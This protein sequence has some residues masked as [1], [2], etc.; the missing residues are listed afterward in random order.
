MAPMFGSTQRWVPPKVSKPEQPTFEPAPSSPFGG[1]QRWQPP[2]PSQATTIGGAQRWQP[3]KPSPSESPKSTPT[4]ASQPEGRKE[5]HGASLPIMPN[6]Q[7]DAP[8]KPP[9]KPKKRKRDSDAQLDPEHDEAAATPKKHKTVLS[10]FEKVSR[11]VKKQ[12][13]Q[14]PQDELES[15]PEVVLRGLQPLPQPEPVPEP[16]FKP[17]FSVLPTWLAQPITVEASKRVP[18]DQLGVEPT[19]VKKL[20][21]HGYTEALAVQSVLLPMLQ[22]GYGQ[23]VGDICV[24]A[25]TGSGKTMAYLLPI[26]EALR[27]RTT[28]VLSAI[29]VVPTRQLVDQ[30][31]QVAEELCAGTKIKVGTAVGSVPFA[32]EQKHLVKMRAQY[33]PKRAA[34]LHEKVRQQRETGFVENRGL[35]DDLMTLPADHVP[36]YDSGNDILICTPGRLVEHLESTTGFLL[37]G[38][39]W[40]VI[41][42]ADQLLNQNFQGWSTV[43]M[44]ALHGETPADMMDTQERLRRERQRLGRG[45]PLPSSSARRVTK[46]VLSATMEKN[47]TKLGALRLKRPKLVHVQ[48]EH[49]QYL[50]T[51]EGDSFD[52][53]STLSEFAVPV[54]DGQKKPLYL[55]YLLLT[56]V[57]PSVNE[58]GHKEASDSEDDEDSSEDTSGD[59]SIEDSDS[60]SEEKPA[61]KPSIAK[62]KNRVL[63][64]TKSNESASRLS[65]L[66]S[67]L[68]PSFKEYLQTMT[69][70]STAKASKKLLRSF[71]SGSVKILVASDA[72]SRGL[73]IPD[74]T[75]V[76]NYDIPPGV[77]NYVHRIGRTAR[78][79]KPGEAWTLVMKSEAAWFWK[80]LARGDN[81]RRGDKKVTRVE[82]KERNV[83]YNRRR[84]YEA[85][86]AE[87]QEAVAGADG[88]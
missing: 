55:L 54:G 42:E 43:L 85:A 28:P 10:K 74:I 35:I 37:R 53:P 58:D 68:E 71:S 60:E 64:F 39:R 46:V 59:L 86:L 17:T 84:T 7:E 72:A 33:D 80:Q 73:D 82:W 57:F 38:I 44:D 50:A 30:A 19:F 40:L 27:D 23:H 62:H 66:L 88:C 25:R 45:P 29:I 18:F 31:L 48:D 6:A 77:T 69:P 13:Q 87:L 51:P 76:I 1:S 41:D 61:E 49:E 12:H 11:K 3:P 83:E 8:P 67:V 47:L 2:K 70:S 36:R 78:A 79:G 15:K 81:I 21:K 5:A 20:E 4:A 16:T 52:L 9:K 32:T 34:L 22:P 14:K 75:H 63:I 24:S 26:T 65:H 56:C